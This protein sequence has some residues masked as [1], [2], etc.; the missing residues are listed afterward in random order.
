[1]TMQRE[2]REQMSAPIDFETRWLQIWQ[3]LIARA[4][5]RQ[6]IQYNHI[7]STLKWNIVDSH[8]GPHFDRVSSFC[9]SRQLPNLTVLVVSKATGRPGASYRDDVDVDRDREK[10]FA[11]NWFTVIPPSR[12]DLTEVRQ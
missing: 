3:V 9:K 10:V 1:M 7:T 4:S 6:T 12:E 5:N 11:T 8:F 2:Y